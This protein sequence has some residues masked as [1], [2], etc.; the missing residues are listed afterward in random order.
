MV[1]LIK[2]IHLHSFKSMPAGV[3]K[4]VDA[5]DL[6]S[7][8]L[9]MGVRVPPPAQK[10]ERVRRAKAMSRSSDFFFALALFL[11]PTNAIL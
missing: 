10:S 6:G 11:A 8:V 4:L 2:S 3:A 7:S 1:Y 9:D 5:L